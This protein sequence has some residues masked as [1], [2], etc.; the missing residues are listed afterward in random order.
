MEVSEQVIPSRVKGF[1]EEKAWSRSELARRAGI[2][3]TT[4]TRMEAGLPTRKEKRL[5]VARAL[6]KGYNTV[7]PNDED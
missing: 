5:R 1:R 3:S 2:V 4:V 7:F 6:G